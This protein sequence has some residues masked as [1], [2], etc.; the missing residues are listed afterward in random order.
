MDI[1]IN[2]DMALL[3][4]RYTRILEG[5]YGIGGAPITKAQLVQ[6]IKDTEANRK[7]ANFFSVT[8]VTKETTNKAPLPAFVLPGLK[9]GKTYFAKISQVNIQVGYDYEAARNKEL[10]SQGKT[11]DFVAQPSIYTPVDGSKILGEK[12]GQIYIRYRPMS[13]A[14]EFKPVVVKATRDNPTAAS[15]FTV[16]TKDEVKQYKSGA[17]ASTTSVEV[18]TIS[19]DSVVAA[20]IAG[21]AYVVTDLDPVRKAIYTA[22]NAPKPT[23]EPPPAPPA[24]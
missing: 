24:A 13:T 17:A 1:M 22:G 4:E 6:L 23:V 14:T 11:A 5:Q 9:N 21:R 12:G 3:T 10:T 15:D 20:N 2:K 19:L 8:Q 18:R 7:G 16:T